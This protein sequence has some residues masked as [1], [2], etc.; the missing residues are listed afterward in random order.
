MLVKVLMRR[1]VK[2]GNTREVFSLI[3]KIG[4]IYPKKLQKPPIVETVSGFSCADGWT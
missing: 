3:R 2:N 1:R 4:R